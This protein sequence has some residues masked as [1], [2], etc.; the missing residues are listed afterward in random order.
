MQAEAC[1]ERS[2]GTTYGIM[3]CM[4][5]EGDAWDDLLKAM[6]P[7]LVAQAAEDDA[8]SGVSA[9]QD[10]LKQAQ[11]AWRDFREAECAHE[12][13]RW[14]DGSFRMVAGAQCRLRMTAE[15][16]LTF[17]DWLDGGL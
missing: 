9:S 2:G 4:L 14:G 7:K 1:G 6:W 15:R 5:A 10:T 16:A 12:Y 17:R 8:G 13:A 3:T 11:A